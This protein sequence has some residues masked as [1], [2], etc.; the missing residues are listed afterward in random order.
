MQGDMGKKQTDDPFVMI[1]RSVRK[2]VAHRQL[3]RAEY[4]CLA[5]IET[6][7]LDQGGKYDETGGVPVEYEEFIAYGVPKNLVKPA[8]N[9]LEALGLIRVTKP[10]RGGNANHRSAGHYCPTYLKA[11]DHVNNEARPTDEW[12]KWQPANC[13]PK[14]VKR[15][16]EEV[17]RAVKEARAKKDPRAVARGKK[18]YKPRR[19]LNTKK[20]KFIDSVRDAITAPPINGDWFSSRII[21]DDPPPPEPEDGRLGRGLAGLLS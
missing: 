11:R 20:D 8:L 5:V 17:E 4:Q 10:G 6:K 18:H 19:G 12:R 3:T 21:P 9:G 1:R 7:L 16:V 14:E 15:A 13:E 2:S